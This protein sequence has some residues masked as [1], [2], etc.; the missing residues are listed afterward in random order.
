MKKTILAT[1]AV[2]AMTAGAATAAEIGYNAYAEYSLENDVF[3]TGV[4]AT[5]VHN[6]FAIAPLFILDNSTGDF[7]FDRLEV[8]ASYTI[9]ENAAAYVT[10]STD[11][12]FDYAD[13]VVGVRL[14]F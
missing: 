3:E 4:G 8:E 12:D 6:E 2:I 5:I 10:V 1:A 9:N 11:A 7:D 14:N 13:T